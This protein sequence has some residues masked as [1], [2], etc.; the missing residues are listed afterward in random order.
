MVVEFD[1]PDCGAVS[2]RDPD[3]ATGTLRDAQEA[4][5]GLDAI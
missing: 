3:K 1:G 2:H 4:A 5:R